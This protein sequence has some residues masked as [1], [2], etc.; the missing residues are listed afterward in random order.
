MHFESF[1]EANTYF[2]ANKVSCVLVYD[3]GQG[4]ALE[5]LAQ[6]RLLQPTAPRFF[7][8]KDIS[9]QVL[10]DGINRAQVFRFIS[11]PITFQELQGHIDLALQKHSMYLSRSLLL[12][13]ASHQNKQLEAL[14]NSLEQMVEER[15]Q[16]I[17]QS[18]KE[19]SDKLTRERLLL[20]FIKDLGTQESFDE[21]LAILRKEL[22]KF[23]KIGDPILA[24]RLDGETTYFHAFHSGNFSQTESHVKFEFPKA[25]GVPS[26]DLVRHFA[27]HFGRPFAKTFV[28]PLELR[29][30]R[31]LLGDKG[32]AILCIENSFNDKEMAPFIDFMTDRIR[33]LSMVL[34][35]V[36][37]E[38]QLSSFIYRWEKTFDG[39]RDPIAIVDIEYNVV[40]ANRKFS[41]K[42]LQNHCYES[43][44]GKDSICEGCPVGQALKEGKP[45][46]GQIHVGNRIFQVHSYPILEDQG[47]RATNV[48]NQ[49]VDITQSRE[50]YLRMLQSEKMGAIGMLAGNI[51]HELNNPLTG[52][53]SLTQVLLH[54]VKK[55]STLHADLIEIEKAS[56]R[57]QR[58]IKN[59]LD[60]SKDEEQ[61]WEYI[62]VDEV[63][64][65]TLPMLKSA[66]RTHR[67]EVDLETLD[68][69]VYIEPHLLQQ[70][71]FN[72][73]NNACQSMKDPGRLRVATYEKNGEVLLEI[74]DT[75]VG[76]PQEIQAKVFEPFFT[77]KKEGQ[78]TGLGLSMSKSI[79]EQFGGRIE[80]R[81]AQPAG[82]CFVISLPIKKLS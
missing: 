51:A 33:P 5:F 46:V 47:G 54:E 14:T 25:T 68:K 10:L 78:G 35:R 66:L 16:G 72:L 82:T 38:S 73:I 53:R 42:F 75:G 76:I 7:V 40:R 41:D 79:I 70:V 13:E 58:I 9:E 23:H 20:R 31:H 12:R 77:T 61:P 15:T 22:R 1:D 63:V 18:H 36:L 64:E 30:T 52:I 60:F 81:P 44:A 32:E 43:F 6:A 17:E 27:N 48:V 67:T 3:E 69:T 45:H 71:V 34:D 80:F 39:M 4:Q 19:E 21:M 37:L 59:L 2:T 24:Y 65:K 50:L 11:W 74:E 8:S 57:S 26:P 55:D 62:S 28:L 29:L 56:A 49:Y